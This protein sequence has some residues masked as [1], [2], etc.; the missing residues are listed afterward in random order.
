M[1]KANLQCEFH[2]I[3]FWFLLIT[4]MYLT[5]S[6]EPPWTQS[7]CTP[8]WIVHFGLPQDLKTAFEISLNGVSK[9]VKRKIFSTKE[10]LGTRRYPYIPLITTQHKQ[11]FMTE[12]V[13]LDLWLGTARL[14]WTVDVKWSNRGL[15]LLW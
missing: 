3:A 6:C 10:I 12:W 15:R 4:H 5:R 2:I 7:N 14:H 11:I 8:H 9:L 13:V 1:I